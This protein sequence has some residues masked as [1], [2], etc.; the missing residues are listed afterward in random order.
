M[1]T[2]ASPE[3]VDVYEQRREEVINWRFNQLLE[4]GYPLRTAKR[5]AEH[6]RVDLHEA[7]QLL[8]RGATVREAIRILL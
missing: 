7:R 2:Q 6:P 8:K 5:L 4:A 1:P 3:P